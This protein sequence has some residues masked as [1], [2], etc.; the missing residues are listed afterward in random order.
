MI[1]S[2]PC[3]KRWLHF[4][5]ALKRKLYS[6]HAFLDNEQKLTVHCQSEIVRGASV[7]WLIMPNC[8]RFFAFE[9]S[10]VTLVVDL[11]RQ[12]MRLLVAV[13]ILLQR[14]VKSKRL[15]HIRSP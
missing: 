2:C 4:F 12:A 15:V 9:E 3:L 13:M 7:V 6:F 10:L 11:P 1:I 5:V 8:R 14:K